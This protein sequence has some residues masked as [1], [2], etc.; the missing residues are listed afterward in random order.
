MVPGT[1]LS[2]MYLFITHVLSFTSHNIIYILY[3]LEKKKMELKKGRQLAW[4][5]PLSEISEF[6]TLSKSKSFDRFN[7]S[8]CFLLCQI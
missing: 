4:I 2:P 1:Q 6:Q 7:G 5:L 8:Q 3:A